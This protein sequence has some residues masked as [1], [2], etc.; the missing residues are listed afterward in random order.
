MRTP[1]LQGFGIASLSSVTCNWTAQKPICL[2]VGS[3]SK[4]GLKMKPL[5]MR[6]KGSPFDLHEQPWRLTVPA[7]PPSSQS[8]Q[9]SGAA[10]DWTGFTTVGSFVHAPTQ[11]TRTLAER[12]VSPEHRGDQSARG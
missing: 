9:L 5:A 2:A 11:R 7:I 12:Y 1:T 8:T 3:K 10:F 4:D 6:V